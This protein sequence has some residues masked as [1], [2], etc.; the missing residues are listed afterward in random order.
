MS[1]TKVKSPRDK[2]PRAETKTRGSKMASK[3]K[4]TKKTAAKKPKM[5]GTVFTANVAG[6]PINK[7]FVL[8]LTSFCKLNHYNLQVLETRPVFKDETVVWDGIPVES[9]IGLDVKEI[10]LNNNCRVLQLGVSPMAVEPTG[11]IATDTRES[12]IVASPK[13][14]MKTVPN[15]ERLPRLLISTGSINFPVY[16]SGTKAGEMARRQHFCGAYLIEV[17]DSEVFFPFNLQAFSDGSFVHLGKRYHSNGKVSKLSRK[18]IMRTDGDDHAAENDAKVT[19]VLDSI[20]KNEVPAWC[21]MSHDTWS[22]SVSNHHALGMRI[23][24]AKMVAAGLYKVEQEID[25][26]HKFLAERSK[27]FD[28]IVVV[29]ANHNEALDRM[30]ED[31]RY[32]FEKENWLPGHILSLAKYHGVDPVKFATSHYADFAKVMGSYFANIKNDQASDFKLSTKTSLEKVKFLKKGQSFRFGGIEHG[33]HGDEGGNGAKG[34]PKA[35]RA[36]H[37]DSVS[38]HT[39]TPTLYNR[40]GVVGTS[41]ATPEKENAPGYCKGKPSGW[42]NSFMFTYA[43]ADLKGEGSIQLCNIIGYEWHV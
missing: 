34:S 20:Q 42:M 7:P 10:R 40:S 39:H 36:I 18:E 9:R 1:E 6:M 19:A 27:L 16:P 8:A 30:L 32:L 26:T 22:Q 14:T 17:K 29:P 41:T 33:Y 24:A 37:G 25:I 21:K 2:G 35:M 13:Q 15:M 3:A 11:G 12:V 43:P 38:G 31:G 23:T 5:K 4:S 28:Q